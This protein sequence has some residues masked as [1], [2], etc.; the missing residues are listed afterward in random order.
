MSG[1]IWIQTVWLP[2]GIEKIQHP[3]SIIWQNNK[4]WRNNKR[5]FENPNADQNKLF[6]K[7]VIFENT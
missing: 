4:V 5:L 2:D 7:Y 1:L 3:K 6:S